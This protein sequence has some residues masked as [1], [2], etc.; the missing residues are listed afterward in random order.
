MILSA[1][2]ILIFIILGGGGLP[3]VTQ[4]SVSGEVTFNKRLSNV[5][6]L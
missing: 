2:L 4:G 6:P 3:L 5:F 1:A